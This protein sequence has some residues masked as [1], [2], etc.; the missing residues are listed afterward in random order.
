M[1][2]AR[3]REHILDAL[4]PLLESAGAGGVTM[5]AAAEAADISKGLLYAHFRDSADLLAALYIRET[6]AVRQAVTVA[7]ADADA[8]A[9]RVEVLTAAWFDAVEQRGTA[10][11][12]LTAPGAVADP[13]TRDLAPR[14]AG[15]LLVGFLGVRPQDALAAGHLML[16]VLGAGAAAAGGS[17]EGRPRAQALVA[18]A[19]RGLVDA[20]G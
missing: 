7:L 11:A 5:E 2:R 19:L 15:A 14:Y 16:A 6:D 3:R 13:G 10:L 17:P 1:S 18:A 20:A 9:D 4:R 12:V 8:A